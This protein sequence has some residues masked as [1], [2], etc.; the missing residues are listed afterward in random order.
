MENSKCIEIK[1]VSFSYLDRQILHNIS[2]EVRKGECI[3]LC[4]KSGCGKTSI[5]KLI[6]GLIPHFIEGS[7]IEGQVFVEGDL[8]AQ[9]K[10]YMIA[11][12]IGSVFQNP[13]SQF[14][15]LDSDSE[16]AFAL[17]N[18]GIDSDSMK[19]K[20]DETIKSLHI[21]DLIHRNVFS[22][23]GGEKQLL[24]F[25]SV[26]AGN[27]DIYV[28]DEPSANLDSNAMERLKEQIRLICAQGKTVIIAE[29]RLAYLSELLDRAVYIEEGRIK[30][31]YSREQFMS[32]SEKELAFMGLRT[33][34]KV[35]STIKQERTDK[36][37]DD[38]DLLVDNLAVDRG[39][40]RIISNISFGVKAG[41]IVGIT[42]KN[43]VGKST[44]LRCLCGLESEAE[45][46]IFLNGKRIKKKARQKQ[47]YMVMQDV[48]HQL[49][50][51]TVLDECEM[52]SDGENAEEIIKVLKQFDL[53]DMKNRHP[54]SLSGGQKQ[55]L[56]LAGAILGKSK[57]LVL[58]E[59]TSGLD[60]GH[61]KE[62]S[63][64]LRELATRGY[65]ILIVTHDT[66]FLNATCDR[67]IVIGQ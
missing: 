9:K 17:E 63:E 4:G 10:M 64:L 46:Q 28:L 33:T 32:L 47:I 20:I 36:K 37:Q 1:D 43:G 66:E 3:L 48:N 18:R 53:L 26:Y 30:R 40:K 16:L 60:Y 7:H 55:R 2:L 41:E 14:F 15:Y 49:F 52:L 6:N 13:K 42:G 50:G 54:L 51:E 19:K 21:E 59:P 8:I 31:V 62:V 38:C 11:E 67:N 65:M 25:A 5:T 39:G 12:K 44:L 56:V 61:M 35:V 58:D 23:S 22:M 29:H 24:A 57:V 45:G 27:P 34:K